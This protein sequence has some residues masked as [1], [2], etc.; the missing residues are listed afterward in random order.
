MSERR[1]DLLIIGAGPAGISAAQ[2]AAR[3]G[4]S[5]LVL[6]KGLIAET[7]FRY[8]LGRIV[9]STPD[10]LELRRGALRPAGEKP[11]R[12]E[13]LSHYVRFVLSENL[14]I[15]TEEE[16]LSLEREESGDFLARTPRGVYQAARVL[17]T[18]GAMAAPGRLN[19]PGE[20]LP[21]VRHRFVEPYPFV[22]KDVLVVGG[23]NS[24]AEAALFLAEDGARTTLAVW[25]QDWE[26]RD[27][28]K[29]AIKSWVREPLEKE[30]ALGRLRIALFREVEEIT[31][32]SARLRLDDGATETLPNDAVFVLIG[33]EP[34]F[35]LLKQVG[36]EFEQ[37]GPRLYPVYNPETFETNAPGLYVAGHFTR[38][39]HI[40]A[41]I[42]IPQRIMPFIAQSLVVARGKE[43]TA[44]Y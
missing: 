9:F 3:A 27:P 19:A 20:D 16:V 6:E 36:V 4:L 17:A 39:R 28:K 29:G 37:E 25:R 33:H 24:A 30:I 38:E 8:P 35:R 23:G 43:T 1:L 18:V 2:A 14:Q 42:E 41:A 12:E 34:D 15:Q 22:K 13:L 26:E 5:Y 21:K 32:T 44:G 11:T 7:V 10:E 31:E 40:K